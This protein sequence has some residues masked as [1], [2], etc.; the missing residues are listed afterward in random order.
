[1]N[2]EI[3]L[4]PH[5]KDAIAH[6]LYGGNTLFAHEVGAG[7]TFEMI[8]S[9]MEGKRLG[10]HKKA[11]LCVPNHLTEQIGADF[12]KLYPN[13]NIL[14]ATAKDFEKKN[15][16]KLFAKITTGDYDAVIIGHSQLVKLPMSED[17][18]G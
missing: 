2:A 15:R 11:L 5:Q 13:A 14:V 4:R 9:I 12:V 8:G 1:M 17:R 18:Q 10:L 6:A 7:K 3:S 16:K